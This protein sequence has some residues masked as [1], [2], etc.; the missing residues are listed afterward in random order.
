MKALAQTF[1]SSPVTGAHRRDSTKYPY[2]TDWDVMHLGVSR[3][4]ASPNRDGRMPTAYH[5]PTLPQGSYQ[6]IDCQHGGPW[7]CF[8]DFLKS[9]DT[10]GQSRVMTPSHEPI[11]LVALAVTLRGAQRLM[12]LLSWRGLD[13][14]LDWSIRD[15]VKAGNL[16]GWTVVPPLFGSW[17]ADK[18]DSDI[19]SG[20]V[21]KPSNNLKGKSRGVRDSAREHL[22]DL[23][24]DEN[25]ERTRLVT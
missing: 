8:S 18:G 2:G 22:G 4:S 14:G 5:D 12:Y 19:N 15:Y 7:Y 3:I 9:L 24:L 21:S 23:M 1:Q 16:T 17:N 6:D 10:P 20:V 13:D 11:G 25:A